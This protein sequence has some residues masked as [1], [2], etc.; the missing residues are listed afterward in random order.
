MKPSNLATL[1]KICCEA[2]SENFYF[3][4]N[5]G[6]LENYVSK[7]FGLDTLKTDLSNNSIEYHVAYLNQEPV[8]FMKLN[9]LSNLPALDPHKGVEL[10]KI[11]ILP[12]FKGMKIGKQL[13]TVLFKIAKQHNKEICWV[14][15]IDSNT[16]AIAFYEHIGFQFH[17]KTEVDYPHFKEALKGMWRMYIDL[18]KINQVLPEATARI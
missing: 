8:A 5:E 6:G 4:W 18:T 17:S 3:H 10:D 13:L 2:Y 15:V 14:S 11:Y 7:V 1:H 16:E 12:R 9:L